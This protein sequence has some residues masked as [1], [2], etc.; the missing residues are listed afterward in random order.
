[1]S[2]LVILPQWP[3]GLLPIP[4][5]LTREISEQ[6][7]GSVA[8]QPV[9]SGTAIDDESLLDPLRVEVS[10]LLSDAAPFGGLFA[11]GRDRAQALLDRVKDI[12]LKKII[13]SLVGDDY[14]AT[15][16]LLSTIRVMRGSKTG[17][18]R[19]ITMVFDELNIVSLS[20]LGAV[21]DADIEALG[22]LGSIEQ[23]VMP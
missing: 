17:K 4:I 16:L 2:G 19:E 22:A 5:D 13:V 12:R 11:S 23:G 14:L 9:Q 10:G 18:A 6:L 3:L 7:N 1:M 15:T 21:P 20:L 8:R